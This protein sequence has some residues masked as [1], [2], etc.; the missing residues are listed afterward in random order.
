MSLHKFASMKKGIFIVTF[1]S[2][3]NKKPKVLI[4]HVVIR[5]IFQ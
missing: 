5:F 2:L 4:L 3:W 1:N